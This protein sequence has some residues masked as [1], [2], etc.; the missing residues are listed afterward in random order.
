MSNKV[1][2]AFGL[3]SMSNMRRKMLTRKMQKKTQLGLA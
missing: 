2:K 1:Y 3:E